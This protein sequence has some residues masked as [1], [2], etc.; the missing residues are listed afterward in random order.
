VAA[1]SRPR[2]RDAGRFVA[3]RLAVEVLDRLARTAER[4]ASRL[5]V[6]APRPLRAPADPPLPAPPV[7][8]APSPE[9]APAPTP[10]P[11]AAPAPAPAR[12]AAPAPVAAPEPADAERR[13]TVAWALVEVLGR[14]CGPAVKTLRDD[15]DPTDPDSREPVHDLRVATRRLRAFLSVYEPLLG[16]KDARKL[17]R[18]L[19]KITRAA[20]EIRQWDAHLELATPLLPDTHDPLERAALEHVIEWVH[21]E[22]EQAAANV[23]DRLSASERR[24]LADRLDAAIDEVC[25]RL[26]REGDD[27]AELARRFA[28]EALRE[29]ARRAGPPVRGE[30]VDAMHGV[31]IAAKRARYALELLRPA[32]DETY[33]ATRRPA[34]RA[35]EAIGLHHDAAL[36]Q[37]LFDGRARAL[38]AHGHPTLSGALEGLA[39]RAAEKR[40]DAYVRALPWVER[41]AG[42]RVRADA[43]RLSAPLPPAEPDDPASSPDA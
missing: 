15:L 5:G 3:R 40:R 9:P 32:L 6:D 36:L 33:R 27:A 35:Q 23:R 13:P 29:A 30:D 28:A 10:E 37:S 12:V 8:P 20:G 22:R 17:R 7:T 25:A 18:R 43:D 31:R 16:H 41:W 2:L 39:A 14:R 11:V 34:K 38:A 19:R 26:L 21:A 4:L 24:K 42:D 1:S